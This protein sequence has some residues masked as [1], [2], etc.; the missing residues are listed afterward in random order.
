MLRTFIFLNGVYDLAC[1][2]AHL[3]GKNN[4]LTRL[5]INIFLEDADLAQMQQRMLAYWIFTYGIARFLAVAPLVRPLKCESWE[6]VVATN[7]FVESVAYALEG[8]W[9][10]TADKKNAAAVSLVS[11]ALGAAALAVLYAK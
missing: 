10:K 8:F 4:A 7:Y 5:H 9:Y 6:F 11:A 2:T 3:L 1:A